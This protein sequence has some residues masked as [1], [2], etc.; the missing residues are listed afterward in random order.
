MGSRRA[1]AHSHA[2]MGRATLAAG[3]AI[4]STAKACSCGLIIRNMMDSLWT[5]RGMEE[6][7]MFMRMEIYMKASGRRA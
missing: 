7:S 5:T 2:P 6:A 4:R 3:R 1:R